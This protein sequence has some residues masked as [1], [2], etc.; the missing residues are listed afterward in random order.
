MAKDFLLFVLIITLLDVAFG[1]YISRTSLIKNLDETFVVIC[2]DEGGQ[3]VTWQ[4]PNGTLN[5]KTRPMVQHAFYGFSILFNKTKIEDAGNYT[6]ILNASP[7]VRKV[8]SLTVRG[9]NDF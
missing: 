7:Q 1:L 3:Y 6:C 4:G 9:N 8:F 5:A 2:R